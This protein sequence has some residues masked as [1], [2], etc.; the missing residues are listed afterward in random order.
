MKIRNF[1]IFNIIYT[2]FYIY[3]L[4]NLSKGVFAEEE[5]ERTEIKIFIR[6]PDMPYIYDTY[7]WSIY[8]NELMNKKFDEMVERDGISILKNVDLNF[9]FY[10]YEPM[11]SSYPAYYLFIDD[12]VYYWIDDPSYDLFVFDDRLLFSEFSFMESDYVESYFRDRKFSVNY[13]VNLSEYINKDDLKFNHPRILDDGISDDFGK[14]ELYGLPYEMDFEVLY[15]FNDD[16]KANAIVKDMK[17]LTWDDVW[18]KIESSNDR[19][20]VA[21]GDDNDMFSFFIEYTNGKYNMTKEYDKYFYNMLYNDTAESIFTSFRQLIE[22]FSDEG[23]KNTILTIQDDAYD[24]FMIRNTT[25]F[26]GKASHHYIFD[27]DEENRSKI[28]M[29]LPPKYLSTVIEKYLTISKLSNIDTKVLVEA[30]KILTSKEMQLFK[31]EH[32]G[33]IPTFDI[34]KKNE[35]NDIKSFCQSQ[36]TICDWIEKMKRIVLKDFFKSRYSS[37]LFEIELTL[38]PRFKK[39]YLMNNDISTM[40]FV[41]KNMHEL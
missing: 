2:S 4:L 11:T 26:K 38:S 30:A 40:I 28:S 8:Y 16:D 19:L 15:Y 29:T 35:D 33:S 24:Q 20:K 23:I 34:S 39:H 10:E 12:L 13:L 9:T 6:Q 18:K 5:D 3:C 25:F 36:S 31:A 14:R 22:N 1:Y 32:F 41:F 37:P 17:N 27:N 7:E 21:L